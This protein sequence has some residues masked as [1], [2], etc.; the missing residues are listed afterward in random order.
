MS[1]ERAGNVGSK[2]SASPKT[3]ASRK[4]IRLLTIGVLALTLWAGAT[5]WGQMQRSDEIAIRLEALGGKL[6][7][8]VQTNDKLKREV[9]RMSDPEYREE[10][11]RKDNHMFK[12]GETVFDVPRTN[13]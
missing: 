4:R 11:I 10:R 7:D 8:T 2:T 9:E 5:A 3:G 1:R 13:P 12:Q 6:N